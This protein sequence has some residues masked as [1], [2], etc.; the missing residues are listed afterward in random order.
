MT[1]LYDRRK[2]LQTITTAGAGAGLAA[3]LPLRALASFADPIQHRYYRLRYL[4]RR[5][6][7]QKA[8]TAPRPYPVWKVLK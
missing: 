5:S 1:H 4:A 7:R 8:L 2:F 3:A 6:I